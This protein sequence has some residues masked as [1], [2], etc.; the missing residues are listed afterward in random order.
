[1]PAIRRGSS[2]RCSASARRRCS[3]SW[4]C[5]I[6][7]AARSAACWS[8]IAVLVGEMA[9]GERA[10]VQHA[11]HA[12]L[13]EQRDAEHRADA[14]L[15]QDRVGDVRVVDVVDDDRAAL[16]GDTAGEARADRDRDALLDLFLDALGGPRPQHPPALLEQEDRGGV[17]VQD[18]ADPVEQLGQQ[19]LLREVGERRVGDLLQRLELPAC[20][21]LGEEQ[22]GVVDRQG[23]AVAGPLEQVAVLVG[24]V[25]RGERAD[26]QHA[27]HAALDDQR[28]AEHRADA[29]LA[30]DRVVDVRAL[31]VVEHDRRAGRRRSG[32]RT[33]C[34]PG[35]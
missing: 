16:G 22:L 26:V 15:A 31:D 34:R 30:Q 6:A 9:R 23:G 11:E 24:E 7:S 29:L 35:S 21:T 14:L 19:L 2:R 32:R 25:A 4:A 5:S 17:A 13:D 1:M 27:E 3:D 18:R 10:D 12:A 28:D 33:P 8:R 20:G